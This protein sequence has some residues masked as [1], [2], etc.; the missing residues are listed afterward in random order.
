MVI[1]NMVLILIT[2][3]SVFTI[4]YLLRFINVSDEIV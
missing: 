1:C 4:K 3:P 2:I